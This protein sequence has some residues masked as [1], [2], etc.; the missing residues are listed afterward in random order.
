MNKSITLNLEDWFEN[1]EPEQN[2]VDTSV[3][4]NGTLHETYSTELQHVLDA[5]TERVWTLVDDGNRVMIMSGAQRVNR[6]GY[7]I[8]KKPWDIDTYVLTH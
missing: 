2:P 3:G 7:F 8:T 4:F 5:P 1:Y 6:L